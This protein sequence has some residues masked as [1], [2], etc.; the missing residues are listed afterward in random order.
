MEF[1]SSNFDPDE[2]N[3]PNF[4]ELAAKRMRGEIPDGAD[5][6]EGCERMSGIE[7]LLDVA[8]IYLDKLCEVPNA[9]N[10]VEWMMCH[11]AGCT[12]MDLYSGDDSRFSGEAVDRFMS[13]VDRRAKR[14]PLQYI[15]GSTEFM[16][17]PFESRPGVFVP[18]P[19]TEVLVELAEERL[20]AMPL[21]P[22]LRVLDICCGSGVIG[23][24]L[25][26]RISNV[27]VRA[28]DLSR[29]AIET[30]SE[31]ARL[32]GVG[33]RVT[34]FNLS[35]AE[36]PQEPFDAVVCNPPYIATGDIAD[37]PPEVRD[38]DPV[39]A[40]DGGMDG[41]DFYRDII[42][43][44]PRWLKP[45]GFAAFEIGDTQGPAVSALLDR[46]G[47]TETSVTPDLA[48]RDRVVAGTWRA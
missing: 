42:P 21:S 18:R 44:L 4:A 22:V 38:H 19:D 32:N 7:A 5:P 41:L 13:Y 29:L 20:R 9:S 46:A 26:R 23:V 17:L 45:G 3:R 1:F 27:E 47:F 40:L 34:V 25:A 37:L 11:A 16:S 2:P 30:T 28:V 35:A 6:P 33:D 43:L 14:E 36:Y 31:N 48:R 39:E 12:R 8:T 24:S 15:L 10:N